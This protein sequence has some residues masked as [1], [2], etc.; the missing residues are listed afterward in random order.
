L[1]FGKDRRRIPHWFNLDTPVMSGLSKDALSINLEG[2]AQHR[3]F[4]HHL[5][6]IIEE[7]MEEYKELS[8]RVIGSVQTH[9]VPVKQII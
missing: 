5:H 7:V 4:N 2:A 6:T 3:F 9:N 8:G 1:I